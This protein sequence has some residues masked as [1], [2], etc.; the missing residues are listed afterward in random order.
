[1]KGMRRQIYLYGEQHGA[2]K[3]MDRAFELWF[4]YY[5]NEDMR[6][7]FVELPYYTAAFLNIWLQSDNDDILDEIY[8]DWVGTNSHTPPD[9]DK[10]RS[11]FCGRLHQ[12]RRFSHKKI[13]PL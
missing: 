11:G 1:M 6:H 9:A 3:I 8:K 13:L 2:E 5:H 10:N 12:N 4:E 7:L